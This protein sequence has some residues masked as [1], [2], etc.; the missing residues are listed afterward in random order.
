MV[1][2]RTAQSK[3]THSEL[4][5]S[6]KALER[7]NSLIFSQGQTKREPKLTKS[8]FPFVNTHRHFCEGEYFIHWQVESCSQECTPI[9][10]RCSR[11]GEKFEVK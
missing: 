9:E 10:H 5:R 4:R 2:S 7:A 1:G 3:N 6:G 11:C 8:P